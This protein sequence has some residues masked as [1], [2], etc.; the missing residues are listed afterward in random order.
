MAKWQIA[1][2]VSSF[3]MHVIK[4]LMVGYDIAIKYLNL[5]RQIFDIC[6]LSVSRDLPS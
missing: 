4:R 2:S 5:S 3:N 1:K 6:L